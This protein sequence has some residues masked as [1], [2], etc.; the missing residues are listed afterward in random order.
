L[1]KLTAEA[2]EK[3]MSVFAV[4]SKIRNEKDITDQIDVSDFNDCKVHRCKPKIFSFRA[5]RSK[6][7]VAKCPMD[8]SDRCTVFEGER[9]KWNKLNPFVEFRDDGFPLCPRCGGDELYSVAMIQ[10]N[11]NGNRPTLE[12]CMVSG[13]GCYQCNFSL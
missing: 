3:F 9:Y 5:S 6:Y 1:S 13:F 8:S 2:P 4:T 11:G 10:W 12:T 7:T